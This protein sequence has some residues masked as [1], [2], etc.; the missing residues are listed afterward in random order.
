M[1]ENSG[2]SEKEAQSREPWRIREVELEGKGTPG[3]E[4]RA[5]YGT[6]GREV[7]EWGKVLSVWGSVGHRPVRWAERGPTPGCRG[8]KAVNRSTQ[9]V[10]PE[11]LF[12]GLSH[13]GRSPRDPTG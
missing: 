5:W 2:E 9:I 6:V 4:I 7:C 13:R 8:Q 11:G 12:R 10:R 3:Q 1:E